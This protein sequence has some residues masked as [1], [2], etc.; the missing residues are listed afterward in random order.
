MFGRVLLVVAAIP[1]PGALRGESCLRGRAYQ[2]AE[3]EMWG[4]GEMQVRWVEGL[5]VK[6]FSRD[7]ELVMDAPKDGG[8][9]DEGFTPGET[10][11]AS[12]GG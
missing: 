1:V 12:I 9:S 7:H 11:I 2:Q 5:Q 10:F 4:M 3:K 8:G 6:A